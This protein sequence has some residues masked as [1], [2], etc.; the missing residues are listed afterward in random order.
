MNQ[1]IFYQFFIASGSF[2]ICFFVNAHADCVFCRPKVITEESVLEGEHLRV[3]VDIEPRVKGH[4]LVVPKRHIAKAHELSKEEWEELSMILPK[5][6][7]VF[8][9]YLGTE[10]YVIIEKNGPNAFQQIPH[11]HFQLIPVHSQQWADIFDIIPKRLSH[12]EIEKEVLTFRD[13]F[14]K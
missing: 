14:Q 7:E 10:Q 3:L 13:Y 5:V 1:N 11:V 2:L 6:V 9:I 8:S 4:L 12:E